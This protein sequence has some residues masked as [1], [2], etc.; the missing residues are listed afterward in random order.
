MHFQIWNRPRHSAR[1]LLLILVVLLSA[2]TDVKAQTV[3]SILRALQYRTMY[4]GF[5]PI[6][7]VNGVETFPEDY[8]ITNL[9]DVIAVLNQASQEFDFL[10]TLYTAYDPDSHL[11]IN[12]GVPEVNGKIILPSVGT[13][14][15][16][17][18]RTKIRWLA[19]NIDQ[20][21][22]TELVGSVT[23]TTLTY[24]DDDRSDQTPD[25][26]D[27]DYRA[28]NDL[29]F[30]VAFPYVNVTGPRWGPT[31]DDYVAPTVQSSPD[32][33]G[34][35]SFSWQ[36]AAGGIG[37]RYE[38]TDGLNIDYWDWASSYDYTVNSV[39][40]I[41]ITEK[42]S[43][44]G[45]E[46]GQVGVQALQGTAVLYKRGLFPDDSFEGDWMKLVGDK[47]LFNAS[48]PI[49]L[50]AAGQDEY[51]V[52][53]NGSSLT[54]IFNWAD[55]PLPVVSG[56]KVWGESTEDEKGY[57]YKFT[58]G[59][60]PRPVN[61]I[62]PP[63]ALS[64]N[65]NRIIFAPEF[66][67]VL[68]DS[69]RKQGIVP[70]G[71]GTIETSFGEAVKIDL[72]RGRS[73]QNQVA[74][75]GSSSDGFGSPIFCGSPAEFE[76]LY[77]TDALHYADPPIGGA[78]YVDPPSTDQQAFADAGFGSRSHYLDLFFLPRLRQVKGGDLLV[79]ITYNGP[80]KKTLNFY[81]ISDVGGKSGRFYSVNGAPFKT[82][83]LENPTVDGSG[84][85]QETRHLRITE[86]N[87]VYREITF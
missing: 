28:D 73:D 77:D 57:A 21:R 46:W 86:D 22:A 50:E 54:S 81:W 74:W 38:T 41:K 56:A 65:L 70:Y 3:E 36:A 45:S 19:S 85:A 82:I 61:D 63:V 14:T 84:L 23:N 25:E 18:W 52:G 58:V 35:A 29:E 37:T 44:L 9:T 32:T 76:V 47:L 53:D 78:T 13:F 62:D 71:F 12:E 43:D 49:V 33:Y 64:F 60:P 48:L 8:T 42:L 75:L 83:V 79:D 39:S 66:P 27:H 51:K 6:D 10:K 26:P 20:L 80:Y 15:V 87:A 11:L 2:T 30:A 7:W 55:V 17:N 1:I 4:A 31:F 67:P 24:H 68:P 16:D 69:G 34:L 5:T 40:Q 72:G 59:G